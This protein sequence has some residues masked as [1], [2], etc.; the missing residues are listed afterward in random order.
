MVD[1]IRSIDCSIFVCDYDYN[2]PSIEHLQNTHKRLYDRYREVRKDVP[3]VFISRPEAFC[4][5]TADKRAEIIR[6]T[7]ES[8]ITCGD[9][10]VYFIDGRRFFPE[11][12]KYRCQVDGIHPND[13]GFY[14]MSEK[15]GNVIIEILNSQN[16]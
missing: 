4:S 12:V 6:S 10:S 14:F 15:I 11:E 9:K 5:I 2:T 16:I 3:I 8:A 7:Y 13:L 1:Y